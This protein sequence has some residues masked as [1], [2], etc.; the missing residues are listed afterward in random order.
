[1]ILTITNARGVLAETIH[2]NSSYTYLAQASTDLGDQVKAN[3]KK[4]Q[5]KAQETYGNI[6]GDRKAQIEGKVNQAS[7]NRVWGIGCG[8]WG[9]LL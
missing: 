2:V 5:G 9:L 4:A 6:T 1:M 3:L 8:V 7:M